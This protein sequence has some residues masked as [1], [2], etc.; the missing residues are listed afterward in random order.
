VPFYIRPMP[1]SPLPVSRPSALKAFVGVLVLNALL[2]FG[3]LYQTYKH[4]GPEQAPMD[5]ATFMTMAEEG[6]AAVHPPFRYRVLTPMIVRAMD[7]L[8]GYGIAVDDASG[9]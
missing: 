9:V 7:V 3:M 4:Y 5:T 8:P 6:P 2:A 1:E